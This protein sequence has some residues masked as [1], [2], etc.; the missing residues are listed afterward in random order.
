MQGRAA[1][2][3]LVDDLLVV[4]V[5]EL[6]VLEHQH[7]DHGALRLTLLKALTDLDEGVQQV[8]SRVRTREDAVRR[9]VELLGVLG[10]VHDDRGAV[11][12]GDEGDVRLAGEGVDELVNA[13]PDHLQA[14]VGGLTVVDEQRDR[15]RLGR[16]LDLQYLPADVVLANG[17]VFSG[18][19]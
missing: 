6:H 2:V 1:L 17:E 13:V 9:R 16:G 14:L 11:T 15:H 19:P 5:A 12:E 7:G 3:Q 4:A 8:R 10:V 18:E